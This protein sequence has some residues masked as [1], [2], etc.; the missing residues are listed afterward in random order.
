MSNVK[1]SLAYDIESLPNYFSVVF[2]NV[3][4]YLHNCK[5]INDKGDPIALSD[6]YSVSEIED[7]LSKVE[8]YSFAISDFNDTDA[9]KLYEFLCYIF[10][11]NVTTTL[12][13]FNSKDYDNLMLNAFLIYYRNCKDIK[14][15]LT[16]LN[17]I[18]KDIIKSQ[19]EDTFYQNQTLNELRKVQINYRT[20]D[21]QKVFALN[22]AKKSLKQTSI[23]IKWYNLLEFDISKF[24]ITEKDAHYYRDNHSIYKGASLE[25]LNESVGKWERYITPEILETM[26]VYNYNDVFMVCEIIRLKYEE[27]CL[28]FDISKEY[29]VNVLSASRAKIAD[30]LIT[31][32]YSQFSGLQPN[33]F[34]NLRTF[35]KGLSLLDC[36]SHKVHFQ[37]IEL[38]EFLSK[39]KRMQIANTKGDLNETLTIGDTVYNVAL[40]GLH[41]EDYPAIFKASD[42]ISYRDCDVT[43]FYPINI[44]NNNIKPKHL[45]KNA[46]ERL[47]TLLI[48]G[49]IEAKRNGQKTKAEALKIVINSGLFGKLNFIDFWLF[50]MKAAMQ[51]TINGQLFLLMLIEKLEL[52][53][54]RVISANTD[55]IVSE[56][57]K[58]LESEYAR[59]CAEWEAELG[60][61]LEYT[62][63]E[64]YVRRDV[65]HYF[66]IKPNGSAKLKGHLN[67]KLFVEDLLKGYDAP[68]V[69]TAVFNYFA[70]GIDVMTTLR[71][72]TNILDFCKT[73]NI[74]KASGVY[75]IQV[76]NGETVVNEINRA[77]R[78]YVSNTGICIK[79]T[80]DSKPNPLNGNSICANQ[81]V[82]ML[83]KLD[84]T[85]IEYRNIKYKYYYDCIMEVIRIIETSP[86]IS[87]SKRKKYVSNNYGM[88]NKL[89]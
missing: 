18:S 21:I 37:T 54:I 7:M 3:H 24:P 46:W 10:Q 25:Y 43:S 52:A 45:D 62:D 55:G 87:N 42:N 67:N 50:D 88:I 32:L 61:N 84:N 15:L 11:N 56:I 51:V 40:G 2:V 13:G 85:P 74:K 63:Y 30:I 64:L 34:E 1:I 33:E 70:K 59:I 77:I 79:T 23:N 36:I 58:E 57:P 53:G 5:C 44:R 72:A 81:Y 73:Q 17:N 78:F 75:T 80:T 66:T 69:P 9:K 49:R 31:K 4:S 68:I 20:C 76:V 47:I 8:S 71:D 16:K 60:F 38:T 35:R 12:F 29:N 48:N 28:R 41:S 26:K 65:N 83:L 14:E 82:T 19:N 22:K 6:K 39:L 89:F 27:I 86:K